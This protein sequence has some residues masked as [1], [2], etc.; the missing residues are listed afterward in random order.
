MAENERDDP[1]VD[2]EEA[3]RRDLLVMRAGGHA[4][5]VFADEAEEVTKLRGTPAPLPFAPPGVLGL[6]VVRGRMRTLIDPLRLLARADETDAQPPA[7]AP[8]RLAVVLRG[9]EQLALAVE[10]VE[11]VVE[12]PRRDI[13]LSD[14]PLDFARGHVTHG[15][16]TVL[17]LDPARIF[18][19]VMRGHERRRVR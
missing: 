1:T 5:G 13:V 8:P 18:E 10:R 15:D 17:V 2:A 3:A 14:P 12:I 16:A 6:M 4:F 19:A 9:D 7:D 11:R